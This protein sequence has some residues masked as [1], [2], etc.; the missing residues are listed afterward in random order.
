MGERSAAGPGHRTV[1]T[2]G[3]NLCQD[4]RCVFYNQSEWWRASN[5]YCLKR[6][7]TVCHVAPQGERCHAAFASDLALAR[8]LAHYKA[9]RS[10]VFAGFAPGDNA[11]GARPMREAT[12]VSLNAVRARREATQLAARKATGERRWSWPEWTAA[13]VFRPRRTRPRGDARCPRSS[14]FSGGT[15]ASLR[16]SRKS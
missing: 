12:V 13:F 4:T 5:D 11:R 16:R 2:L 9:R 1:A 3:G 10:N 8:R 14:R 6:G 15:R 7:G